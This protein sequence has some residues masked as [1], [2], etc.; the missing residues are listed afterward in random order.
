VGIRP[1]SSSSHNV[2]DDGLRQRSAA[3]KHGDLESLD[4]L[5]NSTMTMNDD[6]WASGLAGDVDYSQRIVFSDDDDDRT[7]YATSSKTTVV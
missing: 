7:R 3:V 6:C 2:S 4:Q 5:S 1:P